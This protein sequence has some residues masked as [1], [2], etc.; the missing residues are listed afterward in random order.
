MPFEVP[1]LETIAPPIYQ[2]IAEKA[3]HLNKLGMQP[4]R[5]AQ[6]LGVDHTHVTRALK[7]INGEPVFPK[8]P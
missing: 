6:R 2:Q 3:L 5:I 1:L 4:N 7:W 8:K